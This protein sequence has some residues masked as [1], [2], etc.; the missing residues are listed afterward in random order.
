MA[1]GVTC[2]HTER[3]VMRKIYVDIRPGEVI[4][5]GQARVALQEKSGK[6]ARL[7]VIADDSVSIKDPNQL[8]NQQGRRSASLPSQGGTHGK[9]SL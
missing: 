2:A 3:M 5:I 8:K 7:L 4:E 9:H 1:C 6:L